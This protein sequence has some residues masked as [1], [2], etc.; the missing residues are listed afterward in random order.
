MALENET[1][2]KEEKCQPIVSQPGVLH[3][4]NVVDCIITINKDLQGTAVIY[5]APTYTAPMCVRARAD[6]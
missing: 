5:L 3:E 6:R 1:N 2:R 4:Q